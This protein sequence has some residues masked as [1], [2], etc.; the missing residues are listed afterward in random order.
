MK[1]TLIPGMTGLVMALGLQAS[2]E[3]MQWNTVLPGATFRTFDLRVT[4]PEACEQACFN[5]PY[6]RSWTY[7]KPYTLHGARPRCLLKDAVPPPRR[8]PCCVSGVK[9]PRYRY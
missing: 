1:K 7:V 2:A 8:D 4:A 3:A 9:P 6:C 5:N